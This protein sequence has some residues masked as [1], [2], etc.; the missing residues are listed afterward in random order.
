MRL[1]GEIIEVSSNGDNI[2]LAVQCKV[3]RAEWKPIER[4]T[5]RVDNT[6]PNRRAF[7]LGREVSITVKPL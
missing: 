5:L 4:Q 1:T 2:T 7:Y 3:G 6:A